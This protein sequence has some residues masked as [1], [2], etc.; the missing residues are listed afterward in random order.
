M[1]ATAAAPDADPPPVWPSSFNEDPGVGTPPTIGAWTLVADETTRRTAGKLICIVVY[2]TMCCTSRAARCRLDV[3]ACGD[4]RVG[5]CRVRTP[6]RRW[7]RRRRLE[8]ARLSMAGLFHVAATIYLAP[9][10]PSVSPR[11]HITTARVQWYCNGTGA[12]RGR[13]FSIAAPPARTSLSKKH[14]KSLG[15]QILMESSRSRIWP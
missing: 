9:I 5:M 14:S 15:H 4:A 2:A 10:A 7:R 1:P 12:R 11:Q 13:A 8:I 3:G 6:P